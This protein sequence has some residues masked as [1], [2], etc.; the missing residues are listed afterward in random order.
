MNNSYELA[1]KNG[2]FELEDK[3]PMALERVGF[4]CAVDNY[5]EKIYVAG[6]CNAPQKPND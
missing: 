1:N 5:G 4:G 6:G 2:K 3:A